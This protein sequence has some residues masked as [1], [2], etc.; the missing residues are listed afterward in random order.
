MQ[1]V[2]GMVIANDIYT[3]DQHLIM[4][5]NT[6]LT[7]KGIIRL[8]F[9]S[10]YEF[11]IYSD[12]ALDAETELYE[13]T[14]YEEIKRSESFKRFK[15]NYNVSLDNLQSSIESFSTGSKPVDPQELLLDVSKIISQCNTNIEL[16]NMLHCMRQYD[17]STYVHSLNVSLICNIIG[18]WLKFDEKELEILTLSGLLHDIGKIMLPPDIITKPDK[19]TED[20]YSTIKTHPLRG[21]KLLK[22]TSIDSHVKYAVLMHHERCDGSGYPYGFHSDQID[23]YAKIVSVA[24]VYDAM[25]CARVYR[26]PLCPFEAVAVFENEGF[27]KYDP[28]YI[29]TFLE[30]IVQTYLHNTVLLS[31]K[32]VGQIVFINKHA[33]SRPVVMVGEEFIDLS[34]DRSIQIL[35]IM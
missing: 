16:F 28:K 2:P 4:P 3:Q 21:Y 29:L 7:D 13:S 35:S 32:M 10:I 9:Y 33:L 20:E 26:G 14:F 12:D 17:D 22:G 6:K 8:D 34:K 24:D 1:A 31:N 23:P 5:K 27:L 15:Q 30:G 19:L 18:K 25:T 11:S